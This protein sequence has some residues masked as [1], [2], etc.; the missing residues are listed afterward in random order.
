MSVISHNTTNHSRLHVISKF[1]FLKLV[2]GKGKWDLYYET[3]NICSVCFK[4]KL[5]NKLNKLDE[6]IW[7]VTKN[8][9]PRSK[10]KIRGTYNLTKRLSSSYIHRLNLRLKLIKVCIFRFLLKRSLKKFWKFLGKLPWWIV[11]CL[12][13]HVELIFAMNVL[14]YPRVF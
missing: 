1:G 9:V 10:F 5:Q 4:Q 2:H 7:K 3:W 11:I 13:F 12:K 8:L 14:H 6:A